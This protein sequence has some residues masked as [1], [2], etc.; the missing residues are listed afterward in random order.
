MDH[1]RIL[2]RAV[3]VVRRHRALWILGFLWALVGGGGGFGSGFPNI[4]G[5][6]RWEMDEG[7][8]VAPWGDRFG[9]ANALDRFR[10]LDPMAIAGILALACLA[11]L[12]VAIVVTVA[13]YVLQAGIF[14][15]LDRLDRE[16]VEPTVRTA[17][18]EGW[19]R[20]T[21]RPFLQNLIVGIP[22]AVVSV[23]LLLPA[24]SPLLL[25]ASDADGAKALGIVMA[26]GLCLGWLLLVIGAGIVVGVLQHLWWRAAVLDDMGFLDA[27]GHAWRLARGNVGSLGIMWLLMFGA[28]ILWMV[29]GIVLLVLF[30]AL[31]AVVA[32]IPAYLLWQSTH[33]LLWP[34]VYGIPV[35]L[36]TLGVPVLLAGGLYLVFDAS[37]WTQV[38]RALTGAARPVFAPDVPF[39]EPPLIA[40]PMAPAS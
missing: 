5:N 6:F 11:A 20:R 24:L 40:S 32:G 38:Y 23:L 25:L 15:S 8:F 21:W 7:D 3:E 1:V 29:I 37:V 14:R 9:H 28:Q 39:G 26:G 36:V 35:G 22:L 34:L 18:R 31:T 13:R 33:A 2:E 16:E 10:D 4:G 12:L 30:G 17:W 27:I 19:H